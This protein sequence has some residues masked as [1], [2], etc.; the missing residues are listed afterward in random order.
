[1]N[2]PPLLGF[3]SSMAAI[4]LAAAMVTPTPS[5]TSLLVGGRDGG[6][7][8]PAG[9]SA[10]SAASSARDCAAAAWATRSSYSSPVSRPC[11]SAALTV[12]IARAR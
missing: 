5:R 12:L 3:D 6:S 11:P 1:M 10:T 2:A 7:I 4:T 9:R 8:R